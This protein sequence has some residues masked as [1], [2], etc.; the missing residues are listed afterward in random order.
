MGAFEFAF[1]FVQITGFYIFVSIG[2]CWAN[3]EALGIIEIAG[4]AALALG[5]GSAC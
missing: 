2:P 3:R 4:V 1:I 5:T